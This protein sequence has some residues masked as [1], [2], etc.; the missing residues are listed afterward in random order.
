MS[1]ETVFRQPTHKP[2]CC[3]QILFFFSFLLRKRPGIDQP[4]LNYPQKGW[5][6]SPGSLLF[7]VQMLARL[8]QLNWVLEFYFGLIFS[9]CFHWEMKEVVLPLLP[10]YWCQSLIPFCHCCTS[11]PGIELLALM[12]CP[13]F[14]ENFP[15]A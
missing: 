9:Q 3:K 10:F 11:L 14:M 4:L 7:Q 15:Q 12:A 1:S 8:L 6:A 2:K 13:S 5:A